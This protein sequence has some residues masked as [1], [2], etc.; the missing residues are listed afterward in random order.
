[1]L[2]ERVLAT[3]VA[4]YCMRTDKKLGVIIRPP[5]VQVTAKNKEY[6]QM[7]DALDLVGKAPVD[8]MEPYK[9]LAEHIRKRQ[10]QY[11]LLLALADRYYNRN[12]VLCLAHTA[13]RE[14]F[15]IETV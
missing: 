6:L 11:G 9:V 14:K 10:L 12:T 2:K 13:N 7:L 15:L 5:K 8:E 3:N 1:M 4:K